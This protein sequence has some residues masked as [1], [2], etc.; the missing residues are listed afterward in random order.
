VHDGIGACKLLFATL[1]AFKK[2]RA[3][4]DV[5]TSPNNRFAERFNLTKFVSS[6]IWFGMLPEKLL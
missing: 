3:L 2:C 4:S 6:E 5:G 1:K